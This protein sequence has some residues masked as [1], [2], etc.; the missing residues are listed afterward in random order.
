M[1][2]E[3]YFRPSS[4]AY[5]P[6][7]EV[8][9][10]M[11]SICEK[12]YSA[13][14]WLLSE[15]FDS[16]RS[17]EIAVRRLDMTS[18]PGYPYQKEAP[19]NGDWLKWNGVE[20]D[21]IQKQRLWFDVKKVMNDDWQHVI[22]VFIKQEPHKL[23]K[24]ESGRWRLI[25]AAPLC[26]QLVWQMVFAPLNDLEIQKSFEI[27]S[28][29]GIV[30]VGGGW[31]QYYRQWQSLGLVSGVDKSSWDWTA[32]F[33]SIML[34]LE[35][36]RRLARGDRVQEW[37]ALARLLYRHMFESPLLMTSDGNLYRQV[38]P[39]IMKS[40]CVNTISTNGHC[41]QFVHLAVCIDANISPFPLPRVCGDDTIHSLRHTL[42]L[43]L[44]GRYGVI[45]KEVSETTEFVG[46]EFRSDGPR[47]LY[48]MKHLKKVR[49]VE[50]ENMLSYLDSMA[51]MYCHTEYFGFWEK[52]ARS[53]GILLPLSRESY[54]RWYDH[55]D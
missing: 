29:Q 16:Y 17:F 52:L 5:K 34:D 48:I 14:A 36:R 43:D 26:V 11:L 10:R 28:Q 46:H 37:Y 4:E 2:A 22:R 31:K 15:D 3:E 44:Y 1:H 23:G 38:V 19:T 24:V 53:L 30:L 51:R 7:A 18:S 54:V 32:P 39:G 55:V 49:Y 33:W 41:Q 6:T 42:H 8:Q 12:E 21:P 45:I 13:C 47:P 27:P 20:V 40:G 50:D 35:L 25:M 9:Q